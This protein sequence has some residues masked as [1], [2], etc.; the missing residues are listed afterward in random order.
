MAEGGA[1]TILVVEDHP[2]VLKSVT[3]Q[4]QALGYTVIC[5]ANATEALAAIKRGVAFDLLFTDVLMPGG[6]NGE[7]L[8]GKAAKLYPSLKVLFTSGYTENAFT[9]N[10]KLEP[11]VLL[12]SKPYAHTDLAR[13]VRKALSSKPYVQPD[14]RELREG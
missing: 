10:G 9:H 4:L 7:Q 14:T 2:L 5:T 11:G 3:T 1:E 12:L 8:A 13:M 6:M